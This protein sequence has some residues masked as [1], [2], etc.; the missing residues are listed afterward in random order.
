MNCEHFIMQD[1]SSG[2]L[3]AIKRRMSMFSPVS[4]PCSTSTTYFS[5]A[6]I[7]VE[8]KNKLPFAQSVSLCYT[9]FTIIGH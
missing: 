8:K 1:D 3:L 4:R 7:W 9:Y 2:V 6:D 5:V